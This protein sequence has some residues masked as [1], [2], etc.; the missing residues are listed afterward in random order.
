M[1][2]IKVIEHRVAIVRIIGFLVIAFIATLFIKSLYESND[3]KEIKQDVKQETKYLDSI[4][5]VLAKDSTLIVND[6]TQH[7]RKVN[8]SPKK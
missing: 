3:N 1:N 2:W 8:Y 5:N 6:T 7:E 4:S